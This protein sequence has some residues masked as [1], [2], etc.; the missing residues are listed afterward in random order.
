MNANRLCQLLGIRYPIVQALMY[1]IC[2]AEL[3]AAVSNTGG[4][5][6]RA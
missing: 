5:G 3:V 4:P 2:G 6:I 1:W